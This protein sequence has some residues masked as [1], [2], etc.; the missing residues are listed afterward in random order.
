MQTITSLAGVALAFLVLRQASQSLKVRPAT[1]ATLQTGHQSKR[2]GI[3]I[4]LAAFNHLLSHRP[5]PTSLKFGVHKVVTG[6]VHAALAVTVRVVTV[7]I[8]QVT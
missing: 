7:A 2:S 5:E 6:Q 8:L 4:I 3:M 1:V